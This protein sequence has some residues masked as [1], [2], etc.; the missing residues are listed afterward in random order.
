MTDSHLTRARLWLVELGNF[1]IPA[2]CVPR[3]RSSSELQPHCWVT[4][5]FSSSAVVLR[6]DYGPLDT[7]G[8][9]RSEL[10]GCH[11]TQVC[12]PTDTSLGADTLAEV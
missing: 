10:V 6:P 4:V 7:S 5:F 11:P 8:Y 3:R 2:F 12:S 9:R 1:E